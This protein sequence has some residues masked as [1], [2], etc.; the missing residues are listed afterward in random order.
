MQNGPR[1]T[2]TPA[3]TVKNTD[4][5]IAFYTKIFG[6]RVDGNPMPSEGPRLD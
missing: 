1:Q 4:A 6:A 3:L 2:I 5:A